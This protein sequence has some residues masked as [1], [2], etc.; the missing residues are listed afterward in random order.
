MYVH[1]S[2]YILYIYIYHSETMPSKTK[3]IIS[4]I[5]TRIPR[6]VYLSMEDDVQHRYFPFPLTRRDP[7]TASALRT[8][9]WV[10]YF[11]ASILWRVKIRVEG[12]D[13][14]SGTCTFNE[15]VPFSDLT[16]QQ[17]YIVKLE[18]NYHN[19]I[20]IYIYISLSFE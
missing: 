13:Y 10:L 14:G 15:I 6:N 1:G 2:I 8:A 4:V 11:S 16:D 19:I 12:I 17:I 20:C 18:L 5:Q 9:W 3:W 7:P